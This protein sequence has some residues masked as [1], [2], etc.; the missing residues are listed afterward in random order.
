MKLLAISPGL[1]CDRARWAEVLRSGVDAF[2]I[3]E[4]QL[5]ASSLLDLVRWCQDTAP[6]LELWVSDRLDVALAAGCGLHAGESYPAVPV[7]MAP[8]SRPLHHEAQWGAR[9]DS[10]QLLVSP[11]FATPD[12]GTPWGSERLQRF[13][14]AIPPDGASL[15]A[16]GGI[17]PGTAR[18]LSH[19]RLAGFAAIRPFWQGDPGKTVARFREP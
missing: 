1:G 16:L 6:G 4:K 7:Q 17:D 3:R 11:L 14:D 2:L 9:K 13:L 5:D 12:K 8:L 15:L 18:S 19:P 10:R